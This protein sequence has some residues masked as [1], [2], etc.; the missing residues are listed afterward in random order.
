M[1]GKSFRK[2]TIV[3][4]REVTGNKSTVSNANI[5]EINDIRRLAGLTK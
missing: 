5:V 3:E 2:A 4:S 1:E